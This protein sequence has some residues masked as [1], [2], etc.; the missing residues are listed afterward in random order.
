MTGPGPTTTLSQPSI[1]RRP[2]SSEIGRI[3]IRE[4]LVTEAQ[5]QIASASTGSFLAVSR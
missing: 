4:S 5:V 2:P 3:R 1:L